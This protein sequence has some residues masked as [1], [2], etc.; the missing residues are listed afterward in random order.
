MRELALCGLVAVAFGLGSFYATDHFGAFSFLNLA[1][2]SV[3]LLAALALGARKLRFTG[4]PHSRPVILRGLG[5]IALSVLLAIG[6]ERAAHYSDVRFDWTFEQRYELD[7][8]LVGLIEELPGLEVVLFHDPLDPRIR[9]T[10]LLIA[11][12]ARHGDITSAAYEL[13]QAPEELEDYGIGSSNSL[14]FRLGERFE[15]VERPAEGAIYEALYRL[16]SMESGVIALLRGEGEGDPEDTRE[17]GYG[18]LASMLVSEGYT[19]RSLV[20]MA[21][22][23]I[24][25]DVDILLA[26]GP[27]RGIHPI[28]LDAIRRFLARGGG[29]VA[30]LEP[31]LQSG[32]EE[33]LAEWGL[34]SPNQVVI[35]PA[36]GE[37]AGSEA[38]GACPLVHLYESHPVTLGL[39][40]NRMTFFCG[41]RTF[42]LRKPQVD[43]ELH[44][45]AQTSARAWLSHDLGVLDRRGS[46]VERA[47][48]PQSYQ[49]IAVAG[50]FERDGVETRIFAV[51]DSDFASNRYLRTLYNLDLIMNGVHW[52]AEREPQIQLRPKIRTT[53][54]FPLPVAD[55]LE[56]L[57][58]VGLVVPEALL[59]AGCVV[60]LRRRAA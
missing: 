52:T 51:G 17:L 32:L 24:P 16:R 45:V 2:G 42:R 29:L 26:I 39:N 53:V 6:A 21:V 43:D 20:T 25:D 54:Q 59:I 22:Q 55:S 35:D 18:G 28:A 12:L 1:L 36:S 27:Q 44:A 33:V 34:S 4:G 13:D 46:R 57:Y 56:M 49:P 7:P 19:L 47:G 15:V 23:E 37:S 40:R 30:L 14:L 58:G 9:R 31:G 60:W 41:A 48:E 3:G 10:R 50:R 11:E 8:S 38:E 5:L